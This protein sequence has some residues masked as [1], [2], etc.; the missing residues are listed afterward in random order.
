MSRTETLGEF[1]QLVLL[2]IVR[3]GADAY[4][5]TIRRENRGANEPVDCD[6]RALHCARPAGT[7]GLCQLAALG[8]NTAAR[9]A[10]QAILPAAARRC[11][12]ARPVAR[13]IDPYVGR[14]RARRP[15]ESRMIRPPRVALWLHAQS[16]ASEERE[17]VVGD[18][19][20]EFCSR[21]AHDPRA[22]RLWVWAQTG[23]SLVPNLRRRLRN[24]RSRAVPE[25][26]HGARMLNGLST[27]LR[28]ALRLLK[29]QP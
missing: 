12:G 14:S 15:E 23:R 27:D 5:S 7:Q 20:E 28:F 8:S 1:E 10:R 6:W 19:V 3:L 24:R 29:R 11:V 26:P 22:A 16:L 4:G 9:G 21:A 13:R 17:A 25:P 18:L 2:A